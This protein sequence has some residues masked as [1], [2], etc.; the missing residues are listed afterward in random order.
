MSEASGV[1]PH[2]LNRVVAVGET[3]GVEATEDIISGTGLKLLAK[4]AR[5]D[6]HT[7]GSAAQLS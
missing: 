1:N 4:G 3:A 6:A 5:I 2:Y 7:R